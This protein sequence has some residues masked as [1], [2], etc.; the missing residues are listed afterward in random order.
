MIKSIEEKIFGQLYCFCDS[1]TDEM[2]DGDRQDALEDKAAREADE[3]TDRTDVFG[4]DDP[5]P[6]VM[7]TTVLNEKDQLEQAQAQAM[8]RKNITPPKLKGVV[9]DPMDLLVRAGIES[10]MK[11]NSEDRPFIDPSDK[12]GLGSLLGRALD[13]GDMMMGTSLSNPNFEVDDY[14]YRGMDSTPPEPAEIDTSY[15]TKEYVFPGTANKMGGLPEEEQA[16][17]LKDFRNRDLNKDGKVSDLERTITSMSLPGALIGELS[18]LGRKFSVGDKNAGLDYEGEAFGTP[19]SI[20]DTE[21]PGGDGGGN[22]DATD[23]VIKDPIEEI[24]PTAQPFP[25]FPLGGQTF[26]GQAALSPYPQNMTP[27]TGV[28]SLSPFQLMPPEEREYFEAL[29]N[30]NR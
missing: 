13:D 24:S 14:N 9:E 20:F 3:L 1:P 25:I 10:G 18:D 8:Q 5:D 11:A 2:S 19:D 28:G 21:A 4:S 16:E 17:A 15:Y 29:Y 6:G 22:R 26:P 12:K 7:S 30:F 27:Y 23:E